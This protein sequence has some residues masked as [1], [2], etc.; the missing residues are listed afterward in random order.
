MRRL[1]NSGQIKTKQDSLITNPP[2]TQAETQ[3]KNQMVLPTEKKTLRKMISEAISNFRKKITQKLNERKFK[4]NVERVSSLRPDYK[5][6][7]GGRKKNCGRKIN[8][9]RH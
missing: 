9:K 6:M 8:R 2:E 4:K 5:D 7:I 3:P 1:N